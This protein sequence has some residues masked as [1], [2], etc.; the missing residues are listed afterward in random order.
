MGVRI[1]PP[2]ATLSVTSTASIYENVTTPKPN[3]AAILYAW[4]LGR[5]P[6]V[7]EVSK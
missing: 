3:T 6:V 1:T 4:A 2:A 5:K 7:K